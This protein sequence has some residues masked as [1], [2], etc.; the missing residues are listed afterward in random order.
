MSHIHF[1]SKIPVH[2]KH[3]NRESYTS[4]LTIQISSK[5]KQKQSIIQNAKLVLQKEYSSISV[6]MKCLDVCLTDENDLFFLYNLQ[7]SK[8]S[9]ILYLIN[10]MWRY[11]IN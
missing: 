11:N 10:L 6:N 4:L 8:Y 9:F 1:Q 2:V 5:Q 7:L 3:P